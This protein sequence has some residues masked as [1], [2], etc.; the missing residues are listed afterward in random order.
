MILTLVKRLEENQEEKEILTRITSKKQKIYI[1]A[2]R[3][4]DGTFL[5]YFE[6]YEQT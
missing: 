5:G 4:E 6:R 2:V 3:K 1:T